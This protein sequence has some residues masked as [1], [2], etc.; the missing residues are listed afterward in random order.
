MHDIETP[1]PQ[2]T[3]SHRSSRNL[4]NNDVADSSDRRKSSMKRS[5]SKKSVRRKL[6][7][8]ELK[9]GDVEAPRPQATKSRRSSRNLNDDVDDSSDRRKSSMKRSHSKKS[10]RRILSNPELK[11]G[12]GP[13]A[14]KSRRSSHGDEHSRRRRSIK[15]RH[16]CST[17]SIPDLKEEKR[18]LEGFASSMRTNSSQSLA[19]LFSVSENVSIDSFDNDDETFDDLLPHSFRRTSSSSFRRTSSRSFRRTSSGTKDPLV[20]RRKYSTQEIQEQTKELDEAFLMYYY[21]EKAARKIQL[22]FRE[23]QQAKLDADKSE[24]S[25][26]NESENFTK[27]ADKDGD[28]GENDEGDDDEEKDWIMLFVLVG[29]LLFT[30]I[31]KLISCCNNLLGDNTGVDAAANAAMQPGGGGGVAG[32][33]PTGGEG[34][35][36]AGGGAQAGAQGAMAAQAASSA[37]SGAASGV[38]SGAAAGKYSLLGCCGHKNIK[39][40]VSFSSCKLSSFIQ[41]LQQVLPQL[42]QRLGPLQQQQV[43]SF[44]LRFTSRSTTAFAHQPLHFLDLVS[45]HYSNTSGNSGCCIHSRGCGGHHGDSRE[46]TGTHPFNLWDCKSGHSKWA[47]GDALRRSS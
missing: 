34:A 42:L 11:D 17:K 27:S 47:Y 13:Q 2:A 32:P 39:N 5:H 25:T 21:A 43:V 29:C 18:D 1:G 4:N 36:A 12:D 14:T 22:A 44:L 40:G 20:P 7:N 23:R 8:P 28:N 30:W 15:R 37:A 9:D 26:E 41:V 19:G 46:Y 24:S 33:T 6:S 45:G 31:P 38:A 3:K 16:S 35:G 10:V